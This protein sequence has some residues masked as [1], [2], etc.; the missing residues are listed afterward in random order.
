MPTYEFGCIDC[1]EKFD[2]FASV[3]QKDEGLKLV[4]PKCGSA[5]A[6]QLFNSINF[7]KSSTGSPN[8]AFQMAGGCGPNPGPGCCG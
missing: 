5:N 6:V 3:S 2:V 1:G 8:R 7:V 4:C